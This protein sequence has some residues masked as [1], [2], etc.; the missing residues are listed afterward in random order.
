MKNVIAIVVT[1]NRKEL[2]KKNLECLINQTYKINEIFVVDNCST[3][4]TEQYIDEYIKANK[5]KYIKLEENLGGSGGFSKGLELAAKTNNDYV[6]GMDDDAF[7][8]NDALEKL[9]PFANKESCLWSNCDTD[10]DFTSE[11][12]EV[13]DWMFVGFFMPIDV[14]RKIGPSRS[15]FFIYHD[16]SEYSH[17]IIKTD[18][19]FIR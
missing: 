15:D 10:S 1:Y 4:G 8:K 7:P 17:R 13:D 9:I 14:I 5:I 2:L 19:K 18:I 3:D 11:K 16:D 6:W 12:K